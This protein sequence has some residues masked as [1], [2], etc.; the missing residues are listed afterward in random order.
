MH[1]ALW[2]IAANSDYPPPPCPANNKVLKKYG[3]LDT[4]FGTEIIRYLNPVPN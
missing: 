4:P 3:P 1:A 2:A